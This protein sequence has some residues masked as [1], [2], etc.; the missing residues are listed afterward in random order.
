[1]LFG[2]NISQ[3]KLANDSPLLLYVEPWFPHDTT[4]DGIIVV[5]LK[6][7][8]KLFQCH[9]EF[10]S[11]ALAASLGHTFYPSFLFLIST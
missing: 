11:T 7:G 1:M 4:S 8:T 10:C 9:T 6:P 2:M 5:P 3:V